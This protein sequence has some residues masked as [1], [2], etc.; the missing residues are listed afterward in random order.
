MIAVGVDVTAHKEERNV[1]DTRKKLKLHVRYYVEL[2]VGPARARH[3]RLGFSGSFRTLMGLHQLFLRAYMDK[4]SDSLQHADSQMGA[5]S[6]LSSSV[7]STASTSRS[8][9]SS[10]RGVKKL[11]NNF[12]LKSRMASEP[13]LHANTLSRS[14]TDV[15]LPY[16][17][18]FPASNKLLV[19]LETSEA[20]DDAKIAVRTQALFEYYTQLFNAEDG[21]LFLDLIQ[22]R[23]IE[24]T[25]RN[26]NQSDNDTVADAPQSAKSGSLF[27]FLARHSSTKHSNHDKTK[28][29][30]FLAPVQVS[31]SGKVRALK[32][33][34]LHTKHRR[35][36]MV[37]QAS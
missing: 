31:S 33:S 19:H 28:Q 34:H 20:K 17:P 27:K 7:S 26:S 4:Y 25:E 37:S 3:T 6:S 18:S 9:L 11:V 16:V 10:P 23:S 13:T 32:S 2:V 14:N 29:L 24:Y 22:Q 30:E 5:R 1:A 8:S 21:E 12:R 35:E 36:S 15:V